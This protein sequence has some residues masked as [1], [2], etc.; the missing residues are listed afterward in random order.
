MACN[1]T[2]VDDAVVQIVATADGKIKEFDV[3]CWNKCHID[4]RKK[5][6]FSVK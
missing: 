4:V 2:N 3:Q 1:A 5:C 6:C